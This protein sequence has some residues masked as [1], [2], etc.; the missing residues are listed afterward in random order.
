MPRATCKQPVAGN[1]SGFPDCVIKATALG[2]M[3]MAGCVAPSPE[4]AGLGFQRDIR[5]L[6]ARYCH[7]CHGLE[8]RESELDLRTLKSALAGGD[9]GP[10]IIPGKPDESLLV[11][12]L[13]DDR[14]PPKGSKPDA[15]QI[16]LIRR[17]VMAGAPP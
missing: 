1:F 10:V 6:L 16:A 11:D 15:T 17:W 12:M 8:A 14:M 2:A 13:V 7:Q 9:S 5:P 3:L 4:S